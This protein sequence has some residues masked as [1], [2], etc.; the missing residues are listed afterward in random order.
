M[1]YPN[2]IYGINPLVISRI[3]AKKGRRIGRTHPYKTLLKKKKYPFL[4]KIGFFEDDN[5]GYFR[6]PK[7]HILGSDGNAIRT[8]TCRSNGHAE[9][10]RDD[11]M[12]ELNEK[13]SNY[14]G[15]MKHGNS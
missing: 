12:L 5:W 11:L 3:I 2:L 6:N 7:V 10:L 15:V 4:G 8:I 14:Q 9:E 1:T 13:L